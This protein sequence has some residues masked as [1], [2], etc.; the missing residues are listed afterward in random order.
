MQKAILASDTSKI[1]AVAARFAIVAGA[2]EVLLLAS[3]HILSREFDPSWRVVSEY[4]HGQYGWVLSLMFIAG[5]L[6]IWASGLAIWSQIKTRG[7][8]IGLGFLA[9]A[10]VGPAM[11]SIFNID[12][13][14]HNLAGLIGTGCLPIAAMLISISLGHT[15]PWSRSRRLLF[16]MENLTWVSLVL[17]VLTMILLIVTYIHSGHSTNSEVPLGSPLPS[18]V[19]GLNGWTDRLLLVPFWAVTVAS[20]AIRLHNRPNLR[21]S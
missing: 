16:W 9:L 17:F 7:G 21:S 6:C 4:A 5:A 1:S 19:V 14:L 8:K 11:A 12:H 13:P 20:L 10:G 2:M 15:Q 3:L 18:G